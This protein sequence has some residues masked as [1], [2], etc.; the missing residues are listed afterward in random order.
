MYGTLYEAI[1]VSPNATTEEIEAACLKLGAQYREQWTEK[2]AAAKF[3]EVEKAY[4]TL[5]DPEK[6]RSYDKLYS[7]VI[8]RLIELRTTNAV[9]VPPRAGFA[10][11]AKREAQLAALTPAG[12][13]FEEKVGKWIKIIFIGGSVFLILLGFLAHTVNAPEKAAQ[14]AARQAE[15]AKR[16]SAEREREFQREQAHRPYETERET[17]DRLMRNI[18]IPTEKGMREQRER[19]GR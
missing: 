13:A 5:T 1:G 15:I 2:G 16:D 9:P 12:R 6:R 17:A 3:F 4:E 19:E 7:E 18:I 8:H 11:H 10:G 14:E